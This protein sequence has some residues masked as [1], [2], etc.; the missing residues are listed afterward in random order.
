MVVSL[1]GWFFYKSAQDALKAQSLYLVDLANQQLGAGDLVTAQ[2][3]A[4][5]GL[6]DDSASNLTQRIRPH[7]LAV[8]GMLGAARRTWETASWKE[9]KV[10]RGHDRCIPMPLAQVVGTSGSA[11][12]RRSVSAW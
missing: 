8:E 11:A 6:R 3:L 5:E 4:A 10:L 1:L 2:L 12:C 7:V 9:V